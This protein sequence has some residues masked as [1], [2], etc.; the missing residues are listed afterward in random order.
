[1]IENEDIESKFIALNNNL[2]VKKMFFY[3]YL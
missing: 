2:D 1:M 3:L